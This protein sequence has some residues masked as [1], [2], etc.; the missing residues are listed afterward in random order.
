MAAGLAAAV[1]F[2]P[3]NG[4]AAD[5]RPTVAQARERL[6]KLNDEADK[7]VDKYNL[8]GE[9]L[10]KARKKH[11]ELSADYERQS[12]GVDTMR[13][14]LVAVAVNRYRFGDVMGWP[15]L[16]AE[17]NPGSLLSGMA[18]LDH[19]SSEQAQTMS[20][21]E[22]ATR[23]LRER[24]DKAKEALSEA[25]Q[26]RS[27]LR[28]EKEKI[29]K[30][31]V[32]QT[33]L[34]RRLG[35]YKRGN[36]R[37]AGQQ[38]TGAASGNALAALQFAYGQIGKPYRYGGT[39]PGSWDCSGLMQASWSSAG[40]TL[41]RTTWDQWSWGSSRRVP[42]DQIQ[43]GDLLFSHGLGHVGMYAGGGKMVHAPQTGDV[44]KITPLDSYG[45]GR[46]VGAVR[47]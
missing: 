21:F 28:K 45:R 18:A 9:R 32:R 8:A 43:P 17:N 22:E 34:L 26:A 11:K 13:E 12:A 38:Y 23:S 15:A 7:V 37:S 33:G 14:R 40:V 29:E 31:I 10:K 6:T 16:A 5:P 30:L 42:M 36:T 24:R 46:F 19:L 35:T 4:A 41:P 39:G 1:L 27:D 3:L 47:P 20:A 25:D 44:V 2:L